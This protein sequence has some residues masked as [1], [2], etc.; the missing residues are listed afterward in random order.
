[1]KRNYIYLFLIAFFS[2]YSAISYAG[3]D[4]AYL[5]K[6]MEQNQVLSLENKILKKNIEALTEQ[7]KNLIAD[8]PNN[9]SFNHAPSDS[10]ALKGRLTN[11]SISIKPNRNGFASFNDHFLREQLAHQDTQ[12][13]I[14]T[15]A[16]QR[17]KSKNV[18]ELSFSPASFFIISA[19]GSSPFGPFGAEKPFLYY[20]ASFTIDNPAK[21]SSPSLFPFPESSIDNHSQR[22]EGNLRIHHLEEELRSAGGQIAEFTGTSVETEHGQTPVWTPLDSITFIHTAFLKSQPPVSDQ[23]LKEILRDLKR[24][25][26]AIRGQPV[27]NAVR[28]ALRLSFTTSM[29]QLDP[30]DPST[31][32]NMFVHPQSIINFTTVRAGLDA[33]QESFERARDLYARFQV[34]QQQQIPG[35][36]RYAYYQRKLEEITRHV[37][38]DG[39]MA[40]MDEFDSKKKEFIRRTMD[41]LENHPASRDNPSYYALLDKIAFE[42][43]DKTLGVF[44]NAFTLSPDQNSSD[45]HNHPF[46][47][48]WQH[49]AASHFMNELDFYARHN[50]AGTR[51]NN[52]LSERNPFT[53]LKQTLRAG[54]LPGSTFSDSDIDVVEKM[55]IFR[56]SQRLFSTN[57]WSDE[58]LRTRIGQEALLS[59]NVKNT[60]SSLLEP[61]RRFLQREL[62]THALTLKKLDEELKPVL[63]YKQTAS[64]AGREDLRETLSDIYT[65]YRNMVTIG[66]TLYKKHPKIREFHE[67]E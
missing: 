51:V 4:K 2:S 42:M 22:A 53:M 62:A 38:V 9:N 12:I 44:N 14:L 54:G 41:F 25:Y 20:D 7:I 67:E 60:L 36:E 33:L 37:I 17:E 27:V 5:A 52:P 58:P 6:L 48:L 16:L 56:R 19:S 40:F 3:Q 30:E 45:Y 10:L 21:S 31:F 64:W 59:Q 28:G 50:R 49:T 23:A 29:N 32:E 8:K 63:S 11:K 47:L 57:H 43:S 34:E 13:K 39:F 15:D 35:L 61:D 1:M 55:Y 18:R 26:D 24:A 65:N 66:T 46:V